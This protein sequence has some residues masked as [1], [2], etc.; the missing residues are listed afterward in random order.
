MS[1]GAAT[2]RRPAVAMRPRR[3][4]DPWSPLRRAG[5][6]IN[7]V[8][9]IRPYEDGITAALLAGLLATVA[10]SVQLAEWLEGPL[11]Q[12][13][14]LIA[15]LTG[16]LIART[17]LSWPLGHVVGFAI[18]FVVVF[19]QA[20]QSAEGTTIVNTSRDVW[21]RYFAWLTAA[22]EGGISRDLLPFELMLLTAA[23]L[24]A[25]LSGW[26]IFRWRN[27]WLVTLMLGTGIIVNLSYRPGKF[28]YTLFI[29]VGLAILLFAFATTIDRAARWQRVGVRFPAA[30]RRL[31]I[32]H[33]AVLA[34]IVVAV[35]ALLPL[36]EPRS[37]TLKGIWTDFR[38]PLEILEDPI[39]RLLPGLKGTGSDKLPAFSDSLPFKGRVNFADEPVMT[40]TSV[41]P[42]LHASR[43]YTEYT[44]DGWLTGPTV[45]RP[46]ADGEA[47]PARNDLNERI[48][49]SQQI[50]PHHE[51]DWVASMGNSIA[52][53][54][55]GT[56]EVL[57]PVE[58][59]ITMVEGRL[60]PA[61]PE[62]VRLMA[63]SLRERF[64]FGD[65]EPVELEAIRREVRARL[66]STL[67]LISISLDRDGVLV[68]TRVGRHGP[69]PA[70]Q[71][72]FT[73]DEGLE[74]G[75]S[76][77]V[78]QLISKA[79]DEQL[80]E[81]DDEYP[82]WVTDRYLH[83]PANLPQRVREL[84]DDIVEVAAAVTPF[85]KTRAVV[86]YLKGLGYSQ[87][88]EGPGA[89]QD[90]VDYFLFSTAGEPC[91][92]EAPY[93]CYA[94]IAKGYSQYFGSASAVLLRAVGVPSRMVAGYAPGRFDPQVGRFTVLDS[95]RHGWSQ[96]YFPGYGWIDVESTPGYAVFVR[97]EELPLAEQDDTALL[98]G[99]IIEP[100]FSPEDEDV[101]ALADLARRLALE[102]GLLN[103]RGNSLP[104][105][106]V[107]IPAGAV[108]A[109]VLIFM[110]LWHWGTGG[111]TSAERAYTKMLRLAWLGGLGRAPGQ[112][113]LEYAGYLG[114]RRPGLG[115]AAMA[116]ANG[117]E[118][119]VYG[120]PKA[121]ETEESRT[122]LFDG[123][124]VRRAEP[125]P[126][127]EAIE[128]DWRRLRGML[129]GR[130]VT[131]P[132]TVFGR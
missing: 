119:V 110:V 101:D 21:E 102:Q 65:R 78:T 27:I 126:K 128:A 103:Q 86:G 96:A 23:W 42:T 61:L 80:Q 1:T 16:A 122:D 99:P 57:A 113:A 11:T 118:S 8:I 15:G 30:L 76:Y 49:I 17:R 62:D 18:G 132:F 29:F 25:Y 37:D 130:I 7:R 41:Y 32:E 124:K 20:G 67:R 83:L 35:A 90:G 104:V 87:Q 68:S 48:L 114:W 53:D 111:V 107:A 125:P 12:P 38:H 100:G 91:P 97:G 39:S 129:I 9:E 34:I 64:V 77:T 88:I 120:R 43:I 55:A 71:I 106:T 24:G 3:L 72:G 70:E 79:T 93:P 109:A 33:G 73:L 2:F 13:T 45:E 6:A 69:S 60:D 22:R 44:R 26:A 50:Q 40:V 112:T 92:R 105:A 36:A 31:S 82:L 89:G 52:V 75:Q 46:V 58:F 63:D 94:G 4:P 19:W 59:V 5:G 51:T 116:I 117:H 54:R 74:E 84:A 95:D 14:V 121:P 108:A 98:F 66:P 115:P 10:W 47:L 123:P 85:E 28:E 131:R 127:D 81:V 56:S